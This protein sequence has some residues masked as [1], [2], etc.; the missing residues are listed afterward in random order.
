MPLLSKAKNI[1]HVLLLVIQVIPQILLLLLDFLFQFFKLEL[2]LFLFVL[3]QF[4]KLIL[5]C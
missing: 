3:L 2:Q 1:V 5:R 4:S